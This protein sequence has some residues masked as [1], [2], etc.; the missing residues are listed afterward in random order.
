MNLLEKNNILLFM[1][2]KQVDALHTKKNN[3][4]FTA[5]FT[6]NFSFC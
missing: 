2:I 3:Q 5:T 1:K 4:R 6:V